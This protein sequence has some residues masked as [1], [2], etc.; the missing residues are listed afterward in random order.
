M[1]FEVIKAGVL[2]TL[3]DLGRF[4][5]QHLGINPGGAMDRHALQLAN[6]LVGNALGEA[7]L[8][9]HFPAAAFLVQCPALIALAGADFDAQLNG[10]PI[11]H[12]QPVY[13]RKNDLLQFHYPRRGARAYMAVAGGFAASEWLGSKSTHLLCQRGGF[14][15]RA[16]QAGDILGT[17]T[18]APA[19][20]GR[21]FLPWH[22]TAPVQKT[23]FSILK[24]PEWNCITDT[25]MYHLLQDAFVITRQSDRMGYR[26][27][28][29]PLPCHAQDEM[30]SSAVDFGT[31][32]L[33]PDGKLIILMADHQ[34]TGGYPRIGHVT[35]S[36]LPSLAQCQPGD[37]IQFS[38]TDTT[39]ARNRWKQQQ[40]DL[41]L[42]QN[43][44]TFRLNQ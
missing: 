31:I 14:K 32:Q 34:T 9:M 16:L 24:G 37:A 2:D 27:L 8:E 29:D 44:C 13:L 38:L 18:A 42:L 12:L 20:P 40:H 22:A 36:D 43:A 3:Q 33:L 41:R 4:G 39:T 30:V 6:A 10:D 19:D 26:L 15:G 1:S 17:K 25:A 23:V 11:P 35:A 28:H 7:V 5:Y 21:N